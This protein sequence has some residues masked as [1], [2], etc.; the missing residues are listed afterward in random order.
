MSLSADNMMLSI[1]ILKTPSINYEINKF[2][3]VSRYKIN[4][5]KPIPF[6]YT[7]NK[8]PEKVIKYQ[9]HYNI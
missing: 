9:K 5:P 6:L 2:S 7:N 1:K 8:L 4:I 3:K